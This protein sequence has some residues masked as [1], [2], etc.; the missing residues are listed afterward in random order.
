MVDDKTGQVM[1]T[2]R[3][4]DLKRRQGEHK[5]HP[6]TKDYR[7]E[8]D[9]VTDSPVER[10]GREQIIHDIHQAPLDKINP[11]SPKNP[12]RQQYLDVAKRFEP[13]Q[14]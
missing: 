5:L 2:G 11:I 7:M 1:R 13:P 10:R 3:T 6:E 12:K 4:N 8:I 9:K 14:E